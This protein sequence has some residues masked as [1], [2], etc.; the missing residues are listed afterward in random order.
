MLKGYGPEAAA[1]T[2]Q[3]I[4]V[5]SVEM[6]ESGRRDIAPEP[7]MTALIGAALKRRGVGV[8]CYSFATDIILFDG[9]GKLLPPSKEAEQR[10]I[11]SANAA[12]QLGSPYFHH[13]LVLNC[14]TYV[15]SKRPSYDE[16]FEP[17]ITAAAKIAAACNSLG[18][19]VLY[20][21][22]GLYVNGTDN[23][24]RF[25]NEMKRLGYDVGICGDVGNTLFV[26]E[27]PLN[28]YRSLASEFCHVH[29]KDY[30]RMENI[31]LGD[32]D[33]LLSLDGAVYKETEPGYGVVELEK[34]IDI[35]KASG[36]QGAFSIE[37]NVPLADP[38]E[39][40]KKTISTIRNAYNK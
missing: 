6:L 39:M 21:P 38:I 18:L 10:A 24:L 26:D 20:E 14:D 13:T 12:H 30:Q 37:A 29:I 9:S 15:H 36:Y 1:E 28:F 5:D 3:N 33:C 19:K 8:S 22:Q 40:C 2:A 27:P 16:I 23:F 25:Y 11:C 34:C 32:R 7:E 31:H 17:L 35:L 4:G